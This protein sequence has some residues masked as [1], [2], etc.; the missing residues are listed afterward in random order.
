MIRCFITDIGN[1]KQADLEGFQAYLSP[2]EQHRATAMKS[3]KRQTEFIMGRVF[4]KKVCADFFKQSPEQIQI[5]ANE[6][7]ALFLPQYPKHF[8]SLSHSNPYIVLAL[9]S[10]PIGIDIEKIKNR[11]VDAL[12][13]H[14]FSADI[15]SDWHQRTPDEK[16]H[17]FY[18]LWTQKE[19]AFKLKSIQ[20]Q[21]KN[22]VFFSLQSLE[23]YT[24]SIAS[25]NKIKSDS[26]L[27]ILKF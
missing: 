5:E 13:R 10:Y 18:T 1:V 16:K 11:P 14:E 23:E 12:M 2:S 7:G 8:I 3:I 26:K 19:A 24:T 22:I 4:I 25:Y 6:K 15:P 27:N 17:L 9:A 21:K 20:K